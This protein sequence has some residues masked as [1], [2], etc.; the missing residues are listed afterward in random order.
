MVSAKGT[1]TEAHLM[2][3]LRE[4]HNAVA[5][6]A[7]MRV[8][9]LAWNWA[10]NSATRERNELPFLRALLI[11]GVA[12]DS[13]TRELT[14]A[15]SSCLGGILGH[16]TKVLGREGKGADAAR[17][18]IRATYFA[19][20]SVAY[21]PEIAALYASEVQDAGGGVG[22]AE[23]AAADDASLIAAEAA[24]KASIMG[25]RVDAN[26]HSVRSAAA[27]MMK[28]L[29]RQDTE[30]LVDGANLFATPLWLG[31]TPPYEDPWPKVRQAWEKRGLGWA[32]WVDWYQAIL[33]GRPQKIE[34]LT[35]V[36]LIPSEHWDKG[37][38][39]VNGIIAG[40]VD[41]FRV[42][43]AANALLSFVEANPIP[44]SMIGHNN[45]PEAIVDETA[46]RD[47][48]SMVF[49]AAL[50]IKIEVG[51]P[52]TSKAVLE[53]EKEKVDGVLRLVGLWLGGKLDTVADEAAKKLGAALGIAL[54][55]YLAG[56]SGLLQTLSEAL[57]KLVTG[58]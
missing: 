32:F 30:S 18:A 56:L 39:H 58:T 23:R 49:G 11:S 25:F 51:K 9:P 13:T 12:V 4:F 1:L 19:V 16:A 20:G 29:V 38:D 41:R 22:A 2:A 5:C 55:A 7:S 57:A 36:A 44:Q 52:N 6:R 31:A 24:A 45:P 50:N 54:V 27:D 21:S 17:D 48:L 37:A 53:E 43:A 47:A 35:E 3:A 40:I 10:S 15:A 33:D 42:K 26:E 28:F 14:A 46:L 34:M 8:G